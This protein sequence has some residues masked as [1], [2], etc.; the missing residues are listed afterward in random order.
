MK[1]MEFGCLS[2]ECFFSDLFPEL[3][4]FQES[5]V[6]WNRDESDN[7]GKNEIGEKVGKISHRKRE[8]RIFGLAL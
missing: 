3:I 1:L 5:D 4:F 8:V 7:K 2:D 6:R